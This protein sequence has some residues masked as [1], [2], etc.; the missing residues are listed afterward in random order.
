[1]SLTREA[2]VEQ[3]QQILGDEQVLTDAQLLRERSIDNFR[4]LQNIFGVYTMPAPA[5]VAMVRSTEEVAKVL[6]FA[7]AHGVNVVARTGG[8]ATEGGLETPV[9]NS[10]VVDGGL[11][12]RIV[13]I[14][15]YNMQATV[16]C[17]V[18]LQLLEDAVREMGLT[19]GHSPQSKPIA[20]MGG[21]VATRS[22]GQFS[23]LYGGIEDMVVGCEVVFPGGQV[24]RIKNV[25]RRAAGP[26]IRHIVIGNE[27]A[28]CF[29]TEVTVKLFPYMPE[30]N[31]FLG[32]TL[33]SMKEGFE[34]LREVMVAGYKPSVARLYDPEDGQLHFSH[35]AAPDDCIVLFMAEGNAGIS[36]ATAEGITEI[37]A[38]H[39]G[40]APVAPQLIAEWFDDLV[41]GPDKVTREDERIRTTRN[42]NRTTEISAD[43]STINDIYEA[44]LPRIRAEMKGITL[45][46]GHSSHSYI[47]GTNMYF[48][49]FYDLVDCEPVEENDKY[50]LPIIGIICEE[51]LRLGGS[52][53]HHHGIG[54]ARAPWVKDEYGT[55]YPM[56]ETLKHAFDPNGIM[57]MGTI[58]PR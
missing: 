10:I 18:P 57:N 11:M 40:C 25:P 14:D 24:S 23:T 3:L 20:S 15:P 33:K 49:Y 4:K 39:P 32:W 7:D 27:G 28:L 5:A 53:V 42:V 52:I 45:L 41:W 8:T 13:K 58:I 55:S 50:Y 43:W 46:G 30:N 44:V 17:G 48:N 47:N 2:I 31:I 1:M 6:A 38:R 16:Q 19:T 56:L 36:K 22:I 29:I 26:D 35:F 37:V 34:V 9:E 21:L 51:T 54:K 12:N